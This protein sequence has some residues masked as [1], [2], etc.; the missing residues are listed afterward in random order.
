MKKY[1]P[2]HKMRKAASIRKEAGKL[3]DGMG[4]K[5]AGRTMPRY[6]DTPGR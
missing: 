4:W 2:Q 5:R 1:N 3:V 6:L